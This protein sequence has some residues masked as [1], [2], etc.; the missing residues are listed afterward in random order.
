ML[1]GAAASAPQCV[2]YIIPSSLGGV[3][4]LPSQSLQLHTT[5]R[6][7]IIW[8]GKEQASIG[9]HDLAYLMKGQ[10]KYLFSKAKGKPH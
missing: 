8:P 1:V 6:P 9:G 3:Y 2:A 10:Q 7:M 4:S 5:F